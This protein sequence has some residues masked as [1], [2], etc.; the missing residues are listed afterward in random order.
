MCVCSGAVAI[1]DL[2]AFCVDFI[3]ICTAV[4]ILTPPPHPPKHQ[5]GDLLPYIE[6]ALTS[7]DTVIL[8]S[9]ILLVDDVRV[10]GRGQHTPPPRGRARALLVPSVEGFPFGRATHLAHCC[11]RRTSSP[12]VQKGNLLPFG[13]FGV[14]KRKGFKEAT[15]CL[16]VFDVGAFAPWYAPFLCHCGYLRPW[17]APCLC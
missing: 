12:P 8:D 9:E 3:A 4:A 15:V 17:I 13:S 14:N 7:F 1:K 2:A 10:A 11:V 16:F 5:V 6:Q